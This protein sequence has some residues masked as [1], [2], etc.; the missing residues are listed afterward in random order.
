MDEVTGQ[1]PALGAADLVVEDSVVVVA[2][3]LAAAAPLGDGK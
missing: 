3:V 2:A 1:T